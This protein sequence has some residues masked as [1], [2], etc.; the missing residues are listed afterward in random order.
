MRRATEEF[1]R[2]LIHH[3]HEWFRLITSR[4]MPA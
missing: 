3:E 4:D 1:E 2:G